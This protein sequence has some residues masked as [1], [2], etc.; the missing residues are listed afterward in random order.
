N[1]PLFESILVFENY[2]TG[3]ILQS[4]N[5]PLEEANRWYKAD[6]LEIRNIRFFERTNYPLTIAVEPGAELVLEF[7]YNPVYFEDD[8]IRR[9][10]GHLQTL[11]GNMPS[12]LEKSPA[13]LPMLTQ[14]E[15]RQLLVDWNSTQVDFPGDQCIH[16]LFE[17]QVERTPDAVAIVFGQQTLTY[18]ELNQRANQLAHHLQALGVGPETLVGLYIERTPEMM[19]SLLGILKA[20]GAYVPLDPAYPPA[21]LAL[22]L[23]DTQTRFLVTQQHLADTL[24]AYPKHVVCMDADWGIVA[25]NGSENPDA[26]VVGTNS[27]YVIYTSGST[28]VPKGVV[29]PHN[30]LCNFVT[31]INADYRIHAGERVLQFA[32]ISFDAAAEEIYVSL[33]QGATLVLRTDEMLS[34]G[35]VF[36]QTCAALEINVL[37]LPT[38]YWRELVNGFVTWTRA[39]VS[40]PPSLRLVIIGGEKALP[41]DIKT[42]H[43]YVGN[44]VKLINSYGPTETTIVVTTHDL[45]T[46][47]AIAEAR[48]NVSIGRP[49]ANVRA[50]VLDRWLQ[51]T[52][53]GVAGEL[54]IGGV[55]LA[56]GYLHQPAL[57]AER[58]LPDP[59][60][61][62]P[63]TRMYKTSDLA[64]YL[65]DGDIEFLGR[66]DHQ[67]KIRGFRIELGEIEAVLSQH[68]AV[69]E[70][71]V[72][73]IQTTSP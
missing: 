48:D 12:H 10:A 58:F 45:S 35:A 64:R 30:A 31:A 69:Q 1:L 32:S 8:A 66:A 28:G 7:D 4:T 41:D 29:T 34:S 15:E 50:Y 67:V 46:P 53:V 5:I 38:A 68:P 70:A 9:M 22:I 44:R 51:P 60:N 57:T 33:T 52:P 24:P 2:P 63:G 26:G 40:L 25:R 19:V 20:G 62:T 23:G 55:S 36:W 3:T 49:I 72:T 21:R 71:I 59:F 56:R 18:R 47:E 65:P 6:G 16:Q 13:T 43:A 61:D 42:W 11:L 14:A 37:D 73:V 17:A 39:E 54:Y 27:A